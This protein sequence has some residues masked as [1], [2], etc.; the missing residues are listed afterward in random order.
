MKYG[1]HL[2]IKFIIMAIVV[3]FL[4]F[5]SNLLLRIKVG[6]MEYM[7]TN[8]VSVLI[9]LFFLWLENFR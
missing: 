7:S 1:S 6:S 8:D 5:R 3:Q 9:W 4:G 2:V